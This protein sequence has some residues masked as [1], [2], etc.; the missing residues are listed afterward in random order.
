MVA[1]PHHAFQSCKWGGAMPVIKRPTFDHF[2][3]HR[4]WD[5]SFACQAPQ[6]VRNCYQYILTILR[7]CHQASLRWYGYVSSTFKAQPAASNKIRSLVVWRRVVAGE[8][9]VFRSRSAPARVRFTVPPICA[10]FFFCRFSGLIALPLRVDVM[11]VFFVCVVLL[12]D[13]RVRVLGRLCPG[14]ILVSWQFL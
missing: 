12:I 4:T 6:I 13:T 7:I 2:Y 11:L 9:L 3:Q 1:Q 5:R 14:L 10:T 8:H